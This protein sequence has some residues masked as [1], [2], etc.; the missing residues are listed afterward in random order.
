MRVQ[1]LAFIIMLSALSLKTVAQ[2]D[3]L[4]KTYVSNSILT[5]MSI[6]NGDYTPFTYNHDTW[7]LN[8]GAKNFTLSYNIGAGIFLSPF[9]RKTIW[10]IESGLNFALQNSTA[11]ANSTGAMANIQTF[12]LA[13]PVSGAMFIKGRNTLFKLQAGAECGFNFFKSFNYKDGGKSDNYFVFAKDGRITPFIQS[14]LFWKYKR[15]AGAYWGIGVGYSN[16][17]GDTFSK[18]T[19]NIPATIRHSNVTVNFYPFLFCL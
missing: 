3:S 19:Q 2:T 7:S 18:D 16:D 11:T 4:F 6:T 1:S 9:N 17:I 5:G 14:A 15:R 10:G 12:S 8:E 13:I